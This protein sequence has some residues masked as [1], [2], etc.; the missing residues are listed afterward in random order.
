MEDL[1]LKKY[2]RDIEESYGDILYD[3]DVCKIFGFNKT[4]Y[5]RMRKEKSLIPFLK[6]GGRISYLKYDVIEFLKKN[7]VLE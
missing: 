7:R 1:A 3:K 4:Y 5:C 2:I 6:I